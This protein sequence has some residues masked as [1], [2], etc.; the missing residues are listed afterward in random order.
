MDGVA[1]AAAYIGAA[2]A[3]GLGT[4]G[5][6]LGQGLIGAQACKSLGECPENTGNIRMSMLVA[7]GIVESS[8]VFALVI[9]F[10]LASHS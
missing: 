5:P 1:L 2:I 3:M 8:V 4:V 7:M 9:A 6:A 10:R